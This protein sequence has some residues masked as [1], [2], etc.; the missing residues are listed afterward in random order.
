MERKLVMAKL[1]LELPAD[2]VIEASKYV[3]QNGWTLND[4]VEEL[5]MQRLGVG[6]CLKYNILCHGH[7]PACPAIELKEDD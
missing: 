2:L 6:R 1:T 5:L 4:L 7:S 3:E